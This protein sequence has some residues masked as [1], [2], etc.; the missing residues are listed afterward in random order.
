M[1]LT[2]IA[3]VFTLVVA[4]IGGTS[5]SAQS[6]DISR[7]VTVN[8]SGEISIRPDTGMVTL[9]VEVHNEDL[10]TAQ[11]E[12]TERMDAVI[13]AME[14][15]G[16]AE[17]DIKTANYNIWVDRDWERPD[18]PIRGYNVSHNITVKVRD[19]DQVGTIIE[20]GLEAG[21]NSVQGIAFTVEDNAD[22]ISQARELA[23]ADARAKAE[24]LARIT[25]VTLGQVVTI[26]EYSHSASPVAYEE[27]A[28]D[29]DDGAGASAPPIN[30]GE[31]VISIQVQV[32]WEIN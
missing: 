17:A 21:A 8:G 26:E 28:Y 19:I 20:Q 12:A 11:T 14:S 2:L 13:A 29:M 25:G 32:A 16:I 15:A 5:V 31:S 9:G 10:G 22:A 4:S 18:Q 24:D 27:R 6:D 7:T 30:P 3:A 1:G 23:V